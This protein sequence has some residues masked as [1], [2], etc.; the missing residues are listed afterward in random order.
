M[1]DTKLFGAILV[2]TWLASVAFAQPS[3]VTI[4]NITDNPGAFN[5]VAVEVE[6][7]VSQYVATST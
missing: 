4:E 5:G 2:T 6:G 3:R 1:N 7:L